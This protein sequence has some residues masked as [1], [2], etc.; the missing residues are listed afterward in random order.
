M[1]TI[2]KFAKLVGVTPQTLG[3]WDRIDK[4]KPIH[5]SGNGYIYYSEEQLQELKGNIQEKN[6]RMIQ[7][8]INDN[9]KEN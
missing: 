8:L 9:N 5:T 6:R 3:N 4:L 1:Y 2:N 7:G